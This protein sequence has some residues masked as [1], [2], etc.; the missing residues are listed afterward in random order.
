MFYK[1]GRKRSEAHAELKAEVKKM[2]LTAVLSL[3]PASL[4][5]VTYALAWTGTATH[6]EIAA[7]LPED[8]GRDGYA[9]GLFRAGYRHS[10]WLHNEKAKALYEAALGAAARPELI[11]AI[12]EAMPKEKE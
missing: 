2:L 7:A 11:A 10:R 1:P 12:T 5:D 8:G 4:A 3:D 6:E 9:L